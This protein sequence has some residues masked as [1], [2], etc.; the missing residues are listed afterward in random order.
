MIIDEPLI[1]FY[2]KEGFNKENIQAYEVG[3]KYTAV[4]LR[5]GNI[6][7]CS[8]LQT[9][10]TADVFEN[11]NIDLTN[12]SHRIA[13]NAYL[14][15]S[16]NYENK[17]ES[18][19]DIFDHIDFGKKTNIVMVGYFKPL[20]KKFVS[21]GINLHIFDKVEK[22]NT[23]SPLDEM[24]QYLQKASTLILTSTSIFNNTF[25]GYSK[26]HPGKLQYLSAWAFIHTSS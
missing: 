9:D 23:L 22:G 16:F 6:G 11:E 17:Y 7:V 3:E 13:Y 12:L 19:L 8:N 10:V 2:K 18:N 15:A 5:N 21:A 26:T 20:V 14:N 1:H 4:I 25:F 24:N